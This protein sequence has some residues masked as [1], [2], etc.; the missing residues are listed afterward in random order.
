[1]LLFFT[2]VNKVEAHCDRVNGPVA[3]SAKKALQTGDVNKALIWVSEEQTAELKSKFQQALK[4]YENDGASKQLAKR[5][6]MSET[7]RL[8]R[9]A[10]GKPFT[11]L[12]PEQPASKDIQVAEKAL[13]TGNVQPVTDLLARAIEKKTDGLFQ[14][15]LNTKQEKGESIAAGRQWSDAYVK[16]IIYVHKLYQ[17]IEAG[18]PHGVGK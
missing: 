15:A 16:Y 7:V 11:G 3:I 18:A 6:F 10:E 17:T 9:Q 12:K 8:H 4:V 5:Y 13:K 1:M 14:H 2:S